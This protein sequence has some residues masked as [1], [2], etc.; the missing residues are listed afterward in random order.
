MIGYLLERELGNVLGERPVATLITQTVVDAL[1]PAFQRPSKPIGPVYDVDR[2]Q[3]SGS[4]ARLDGRAATARTGDASS[5]RRR[6][7]RSSSCRRSVCCS[8]TASSSCARAGAVYPVVVDSFGARHGVEAVVDKDLA[9]RAARPPTLGRSA[10]AADRRARRRAR[11]GYSRRSAGTD[12]HDVRAGPRI[13]SPRARWRR[14][15]RPRRRSSDRP[16]SGP[17]SEPSPTPWRSSRG[18]PERPSCDDEEQ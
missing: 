14:R 15:S 8:S 2:A 11:L 13:S 18:R 3:A 16:G 4:R 1:D 6:R 17:P 10:L 12:H 7:A 9:E 5:R